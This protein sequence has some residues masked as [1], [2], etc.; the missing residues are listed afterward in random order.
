MSGKSSRRPGPK[1]PFTDP[2][3]KAFLA[4]AAQELPKL[5][6]GSKIS[7]SIVPDDVDP[8]FAIELGYMIMLDKPIVLVVPVGRQVP[9][10]LV[11]VADRIIQ[12]TDDATVKQALVDAMNE[13]GGVVDDA[14]EG[15][16]AND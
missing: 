13:L 14:P 16:A 9:D 4:R 12:W 15:Q 11:R 10:K 5:I 7:V 3:F 1:D 8:K 6:G 2:G